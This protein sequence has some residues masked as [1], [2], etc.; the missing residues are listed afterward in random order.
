M[1]MAY[2]A[3]STLATS[4]TYLP[5]DVQKKVLHAQDR[6]IEL[7]DGQ[8]RSTGKPYIEH[9]IAVTVYLAG[10]E[11]GGDTLIA[12]LLHDVV[13]DGCC[14]L[15]DIE[16]E[17]GT[18]VA[19]LV[20]GVTKLSKL[21]YEGRRTERQ[22]ASLRKMLLTAQDDLRVIFIKLADRWHNIS[23]IS[24]LRE[25][26]QVRIAQETLEI[27]VPFARLVG[28]WKL[29]SEMEN[30]C[31]PIVKP[32]EAALWSKAIV[33]KRQIVK[34]ER[35]TFV[36][37][38]NAM[39]TEEVTAS[40]DFMSDYE[41]Y[42]KL[43]GN[44]SRLD[45]LRNIDTVHIVVDGTQ[46]NFDP[47]CYEVMGEIH[48]EY[49]VLVGSFRDYISAAQPNG[50]RALHTT[51]FLSKNHLVRLRI[52]NKY[53]NEYAS[54]RKL[55]NWQIDPEGYL[56]EALQSLHRKGS[57]D[58]QYM[59]D[60]KNTVL[61]GHI[62]VFTPMGEIISLPPESNGVDFAFAVNPE[63]VRFLESV[64]INGEVHEP[65]HKLHDGDTV[66]LSLSKNSAPNHKRLWLETVKSV[67]AREGLKNSIKHS[68][69]ESRNNEAERLLDLE[70]SKQ[71]LPR[72]PLFSMPSLRKKLAK[73]VQKDTYEELLEDLGTGIL[74]IS[75]VIE[76]YR[77][78]IEEQEGA[79]IKTLSFFHLLP[80][81]RVRN[82]KS[83]L[84]DVEVYANDRPG[85]IHDI[86]RCFSQK[87]INI[88]KFGVYA[89]P[90]SGALYKIR[91][92]AQN[93]DVFSELYDGLL[94]V[95]GVSKVLRKR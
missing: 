19:T 75:T 39:T 20:D 76:G 51:I 60:L 63:H 46:N 35:E 9:P 47:A 68:P 45:D 15:E 62:N 58:Q 40:V 33:E 91:L 59:K 74:P 41:I 49:P 26:K 21:H 44:I 54:R 18:S 43:H 37:E 65:T 69:V 73:V 29:K 30:V 77:N 71:N 6:A 5:K 23:T 78:M 81:S 14:L 61:S 17:F 57:D 53:M 31:F 56:F 85:L 4:V 10:L 64:V 55:S 32:D 34:K 94:Q 72:K 66:D 89:L 52:Q 50:Y 16:K 1:L 38:V 36:S 42:K 12:S 92:E 88:A 67:D 24:A 22:Q 79:L 7:H 13:E 8:K 90:K 84:I 2:I 86:S 87:D 27:Y 93:F 95:P 82:K 83:T 48:N 3:D 70:L 25:D 80:K 11:A 28:L